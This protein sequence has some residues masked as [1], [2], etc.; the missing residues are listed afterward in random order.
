M[1]KKL[2]FLS[3]IEGAVVMAAE[4][5]GAKLLAPV[6]G[7]SLYV[8]A[9]VMG[10]T[11]AA[12]AFGYF[13]GGLIS[14]KKKQHSKQ[15]FQILIFASLF[16]ILM[17]VLSRYVIPWISYLPFLVAV[18]SSTFVLLFFPVFFL[19][20]TSSLF[21]YL[22][23]K[24][25]LMSGRVSGSV[26]AIST[27]GGIIATF[28]C[29]FYLIPCIG[30]TYCLLLFGSALFVAS[31]LIFKFYKLIYF[32]LFAAFIYLNLQF[33]LLKNTDLYYSNSILGQ[34]QVQ[35]VFNEKKAAIRILKINSIIQT[36]MNVK[37]KHSVSEYVKLL[38]TLVPYSSKPKNALV[39]GLGG[40]LTAN[41]FYDKNYTTDGVE[42]DQEIINAAINFFDL[43]KN[44]VPICSDA[45]YF[46]NHCTKK[47]D[48]VLVD[49]FKAEEQPS[50]VITVE[51]LNKLKQNLSDSALLIINWH[52]YMTGEIGKGSS[53][54]NNT[55]MN[56]GFNV[57]VCTNSTNENYRNLIFVCSLNGQK[58]LPFEI[59]AEFE[60]TSLLNKD[61]LPLFEKYNALANKAWRSNYLNYYQTKV[62]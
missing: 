10:I 37:T 39:L 29:G 57:K 34:L 41:L 38:D 2:L 42:F 51:S 26:Y 45:R 48:L 3:F 12:L 20:A 61:D 25:S 6:F 58:A 9:S 21:I 23:T 7:S 13:F 28:L 47:Y 49:I 33:A 31:I 54:L 50:H 1:I 43:N 24:D 22:Q 19:G 32:L 46:L 55:L 5:C 36:E 53:V 8:W 15:L 35:D 52:G 4:L 62:N 44:V 27:L 18:V 40:G 30:L 14:E 56:S 16:V 60:K 11:L 59:D 17:P